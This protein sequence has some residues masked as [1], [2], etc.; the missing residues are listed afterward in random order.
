MNISPPAFASQRSPALSSPG[1][2]RSHTR[3]ASLDHGRRGHS[4]APPN[5]HPT[6]SLSKLESVTS[7]EDEERT[8]PPT[9]DLDLARMLEVEREKGSVSLNLSQRNLANLPREIGTMVLLERLGLS[10]NMLSSLPPELCGLSHLRY[11]NLRSNRMREFPLV[12]CQLPA[13][14]ILD[15]SR[16]KLKRLPNNFGTLMNLKVLSLARNRIQELPMYLGE[17]QGLKVLKI[18]HNPIQWPPPD[19]LQCEA[20]IPHET[21]LQ[22]FKDFLVRE[23][24]LSRTGTNDA[25]ADVSN[26]QS[27]ELHT[28]GAGQRGPRR[29]KQIEEYTEE[30]D[31][32]LHSVL[33]NDNRSSYT[34]QSS[35]GAAESERELQLFEILEGVAYALT[36]IYRI[37]REIYAHAADLPVDHSILRSWRGQMEDLNRNTCSLISVLFTESDGEAQ[38]ADSQVEIG[39]G[40]P[41]SVTS[42]ADQLPSSSIVLEEA[43]RNTLLAIASAKA[44]SSLVQSCGSTLM[45]N[46]DVRTSRSLITQW[47]NATAELADVLYT[48]SA[49]VDF[50]T[51]FPKSPESASSTDTTDH[52]P[53]QHVVHPSFI[54]VLAKSAT[55]AAMNVLDLLKDVSKPGGTGGEST[56]TDRREGSKAAGLH[57]ELASTMA[58]VAETTRALSECLAGEGGGNDWQKN[59]TESAGRFIKAIAHMS[60]AARAVA[61]NNPLGKPVMAGLH[62]VTRTTKEL[63]MAVATQKSTPNPIVD[64]TVHSRTGT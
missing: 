62:N 41:P 40:I 51:G 64:T 21:W 24:N 18:E 33:R 59:I 14:E 52:E 28:S 7:K 3:T 5:H 58:T 30:C 1:S 4:P 53:Q 23:G 37:V 57:I 46:L 15:M 9:E 13:L 12:I 43:K 36:C 54:Q 38:I 63:A 50:G 25:S 29:D 42:L 49:L 32:L 11:L 39:A 22:T 56:G 6:A 60:A 8:G 35:H 34:A 55:G 10:N 16:N 20:D 31:Q 61:I 17:M 27:S 48:A 19:V 2:V 47:Y 44:L 45:K 26:P